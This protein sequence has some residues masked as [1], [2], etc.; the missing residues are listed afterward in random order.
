MVVILCF[1]KHFK[2]ATVDYF[3]CL[4]SLILTLGGEQGSSKHSGGGR[5]AHLN[6]RRGRVRRILASYASLQLASTATRLEFS[7][8]PQRLD[9]AM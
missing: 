5:R 8:P 7:Q 6:T 1:E 2:D 4:H 9:E 3:G